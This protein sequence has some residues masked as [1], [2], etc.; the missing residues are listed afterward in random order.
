MER[1]FK[2]LT[3]S[4]KLVTLES[5]DK[6]KESLMIGCGKNQQIT[7]IWSKTKKVGDTVTCDV[8]VSDKGNLYLNEGLDF[9]ERSQ[10][11]ERILK[12]NQ[13]LDKQLAA[14]AE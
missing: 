13:L 14:I 10:K 12:Q 8:E 9:W 2:I 3:I 11:I 5:N 1:E 6:K 4:K 7:Q